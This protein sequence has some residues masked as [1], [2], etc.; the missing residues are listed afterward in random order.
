MPRRPR[1][2]GQFSHVIVRGIGKQILFEDDGDRTKF[3]RLLERSRDD[4]GV[5]IMAYCLMENHVHLL[6]R[7]ASGKLAL[8]MQKVGISYA[9]YYNRKYE[10][11]GH[12]FQDRF[13]SQIIVDDTGL[14]NVY[15]YILKNPEKAFICAASRY[16]W[17]SYREYGKEGGLTDSTM[18]QSLIGDRTSLDCFLQ[19][20]SDYE[21]MEDLPVRHDDAW[22]LGIIRSSLSAGSGT[23]LQ[24]MSK[25]ERNEKLILL[26]RKG[27]TVR[28]LERL[29]GIN[30][31]VIQRVTK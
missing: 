22:A 27:L 4:T 19:A 10:R 8:F 30:R 2:A 7:D 20:D 15:R 24:Q 14:L 28:Q 26:R 18:F 3:L 13:K 5:I 1:A 11:I 31:G 17:S 23:I 9:G 29:T 16:R 25:A 21:G 6:I 12:L